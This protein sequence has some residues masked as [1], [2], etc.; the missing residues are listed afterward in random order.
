L[1]KLEEKF[2]FNNKEY[3][4]IYKLAAMIGRDVYGLKKGNS[5][6]RF[7]A[8]LNNLPLGTIAT[9]TLDKPTLTDVGFPK[10]K[11]LYSRNDVLLFL[12]NFFRNSDL[13]I[14][15]G[16]YLGLEQLARV[17]GIPEY[18]LGKSKELRFYPKSLIK[19]P[20]ELGHYMTIYE[21][22]IC[23]FGKE[24]S[25]YNFY[26][27]LR[28]RIEELPEGMLKKIKLDFSYKDIKVNRV[29]TELF[30]KD[31]VESFFSKYILRDE[32]FKD[33]MNYGSLFA[34]RKY[35]K[36]LNIHEIVLGARIDVFILRSDYKKLK[37]LC[38]ALSSTSNI[39]S[40]KVFARSFNY[41]TNDEVM[42][43]L[44]LSNY[45]LKKL[46][47]SEKIIVAERYDNQ[48]LFDKNHISQVHQKQLKLLKEYRDEY[49]TV[50]EIHEKFSPSFLKYFLSSK[51][52]Q[53]VNK[54][55]IPIILVGYLKGRSKICYEKLQIES[56][57]C[58]YKL[59]KGMSILTIE[60]PFGDFIFKVED[61]IKI[62]F[63]R[64]QEKTKE[65]WYQFTCKIFNN[66]GV[67]DKAK[68]SF[69]VNQYA[70]NTENIFNVFKKEIYTYRADEVNK[71]YLNSGSGILR[72]HQRAFYQF[73]KQLIISFRS[74]GF[75]LPFSVDELNNPSDYE[76]VKESDTSI[77]LLEE[78]HALY[79]YVNLIEYHKK[80]AIDSVRI[81]L[82]TPNTTK[83]NHY[84]SCW[85]YILI[86][87][88]NN[89]R[90]STIIAQMIDLSD[91]Q[92]KNMEWLVDN[93][94]SLEDANNIIF[95]IGRY[96]T[97]I[98]K[99]SVSAEGIFNIGEPLKIAFATAISICEFRAQGSIKGSSDLIYLC[100]SLRTKKNPHKTFFENFICGFE[101][102]NRKINRTL[103]TLIWSVLRHLGRGLKESKVSRSHI[104]EQTTINH[105]IKLTD[106]Q[107]EHLVL[108]IFE[109][110][111]FGYVTQMLSNI[112]F[113]TEA[114]KSVE[115]K[116]MVA[117]NNNFGDVIKIE[118]T[119][120]VI[121]RLAINKQ[122]V[123]QYLQSFSLEEIHTKYNQLLAGILPSKKRYFQCIYSK[124]TLKDDYFEPPCD[125]CAASIINVYALSNIMDN[126]VC[127]MKKI[128]KD[129]DNVVVGEK[130]KLANHLYLIHGVVEQARIKFG[131]D[132]VDGFVEGK[133]E[134][135]KDLGFQLAPKKLKQYRTSGVIKGVK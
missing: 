33:I 4:S 86:Q 19:K 43:I 67:L 111:Q 60:D 27:I 34:I 107:V 51:E 87:L 21:I 81:F 6:I 125:G 135:I 29:I 103:S 78:Y 28:K 102:E 12:K 54:K 7:K 110:N 112:L 18:K 46:I 96:V 105:Y 64:D 92:I 16:N 84:D 120:G 113:G 57:W 52:K 58:D 44:N 126:Y 56:R 36:K 98:H 130:N 41:V 1:K 11:T 59:Y 90:H 30:L 72:S 134:C 38:I 104:R 117:I 50:S 49:Y 5:R 71:L 128:I 95:Q 65:L 2:E 122:Q 69:M 89:W 99:T 42:N 79:G 24:V 88:T 62:A 101:F 48:K 127:Y 8:Y 91:T 17:N 76:I 97:N 129:F 93:N 80:K 115:T 124:C 26:V 118:A 63:C 35:F 77:Y 132:V 82:R 61:V 47:Y 10:V 106:K 55:E 100:G 109:R 94:P 68:I 73:L 70:K 131:R 85:L 133:T 23:K 114:D 31:D 3:I 123:I 14:E 108:E 9:V 74:D 116:R 121:N 66:T 83:N 32:A 45:F 13:K 20:L 22:G 25:N 53:R 119:A 37:E 39:I 15:Y 40:L 75:P